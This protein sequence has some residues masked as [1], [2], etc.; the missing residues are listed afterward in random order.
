MR[1]LVTFI[2]VVLRTAVMVV[3]E[4]FAA[5]LIYMYLAVYDRDLF[6]GLIQFSDWVLNTSIKPTLAMFPQLEGQAYLTLVGELAPKAMLLL[7]I[8]LTVGAVFRLLGW[9]VS[10][11]LFSSTY[12][13]DRA[14]RPSR[15]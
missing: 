6:A 8:G 12:A 1:T 13:D 14:P 15:A 2:G 9:L 5:L 10:A 11:M 3:L 4:L 7:L